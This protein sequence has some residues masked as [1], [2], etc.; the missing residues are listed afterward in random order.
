MHDL[1]DSHE[2]EQLC[3]GPT[4]SQLFNALHS[5]LQ[6]CVTE[7]VDGKNPMI[8]VIKNKFSGS[9]RMQLRNMADK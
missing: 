8:K 7:L 4:T 1:A 6:L 5:I 3:L 9:A 2:L